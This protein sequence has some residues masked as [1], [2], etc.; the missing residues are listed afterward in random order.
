MEPEPAGGAENTCAWLRWGQRDAF[1]LDLI[2]WAAL[3]PEVGER[4]RVAAS[5]CLRSLLWQ[6][7]G[8]VEWTMKFLLSV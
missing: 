4:E 3:L 6:R 8:W 5:L 2:K 1:L 7:A